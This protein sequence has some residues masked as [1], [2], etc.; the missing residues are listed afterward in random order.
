[1]THTLPTGLRAGVVVPASS[2]NLGPGFDSL[3]LALGLYDEV[4][5]AAATD[6]AVDAG[7]WLRPFRNLIYTMPPFVCTDSDVET[8]CSGIAAA[9]TASCAQ[10]VGAGGAR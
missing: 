10:L 8:I 1:M 5:V 6:A 9:T 2:A 7:V 3:G 4:D